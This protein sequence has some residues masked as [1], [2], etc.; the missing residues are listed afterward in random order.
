MS[1]FT[2]CPNQLPMLADPNSNSR[3][4]GKEIN[5][6]K[7]S[8]LSANASWSLLS[9]GAEL[10]ISKCI[11]KMGGWGGGV[12]YRG[13]EQTLGSESVWTQEFLTL[14]F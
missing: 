11:P 4:K 13:P 6:S 14:Q 8:T 7:R 5:H 12:L 10:D 9:L 3:R 1:A 2:V